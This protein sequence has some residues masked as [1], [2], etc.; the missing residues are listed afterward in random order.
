[1]AQVQNL[2]GP[3]GPGAGRLEDLAVPWIQDP[4]PSVP[5]GDG[6]P[7]AVGAEAGGQQQRLGRVALEDGP[8]H[9]PEGTPENRSHLGHVPEE[10]LRGRDSFGP[11]VLG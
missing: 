7:V 6:Q 5:G 8:Q 11:L 4:E 2:V 9:H 1:M 3:V 10:H